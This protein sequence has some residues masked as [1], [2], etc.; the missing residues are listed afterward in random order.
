MTSQEQQVQEVKET[1]PLNLTGPL[2]YKFTLQTQ[3]VKTDQAKKQKL[4][5]R[6]SQTMGRQRN[7]PKMKGKE[8]VSETMLNEEKASQLSD[9]EFKELVI[10]KLNELTKND[11]ITGKLQ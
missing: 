5:R 8:E 9:I 11:Q 7:K 3:R 4:T 10:R 2:P 6:V 1:A